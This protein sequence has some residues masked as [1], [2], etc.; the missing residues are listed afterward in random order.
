[1]FQDKLRLFRETTLKGCKELKLSHNNSFLAAA[2]A[3]SVYVYD[4]KTLQQV[5]YLQGH[6]GQV[7]KLC[8]APGDMSLFSSGADGNVY[9]WSLTADLRMDVSTSST[10]RYNITSMNSFAYSGPDFSSVL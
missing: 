6:I 9:G 10:N 2:A 1:M 4:T 8:W 3:L 7:R 5:L